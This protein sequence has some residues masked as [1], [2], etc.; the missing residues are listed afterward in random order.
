MIDVLCAYF[1]KFGGREIGEIVRCLPDEKR[2]Q[3]RLA[4]LLSL[5]CGSRPKSARAGPRQCTQSA[6][7]LIQFGSLLAELQPNA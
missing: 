6:P 7:D 1:V 5:L 4:L 3:I 2:T